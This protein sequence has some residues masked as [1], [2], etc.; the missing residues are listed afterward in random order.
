MSNK[1]PFMAIRFQRLPSGHDL[2]LPSRATPGSAGIDL[3]AARDVSISSGGRAAVPTGFA[4]EL[5]QGT[6]GQI[7]PRS[8]WA[9]RDGLTVLN[10]PG[11]IDSDYRGEVMILLINHGV[12]RVMI[13]R[14][15]RIAQLVVAPVLVMPIEEV[16]E[17]P[18]T[19][20]VSGL[21]ST[22]NE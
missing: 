4:I 21:G 20:R 11:T 17:L 12:D 9:A 18:E 6:E 1:G 3:R 8:G 5:P 13:K 15:D 10:S 19:E 7:R 14:G 2:P 22:G 16:H